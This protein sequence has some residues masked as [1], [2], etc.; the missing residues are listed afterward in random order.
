MAPDNTRAL[1]ALGASRFNLN[2]LD[3]AERLWLKVTVLE[4]DGTEACYDLGFLALNQE[5]PDY[6]GVERYWRKVIALDP[7]SQLATTVQGH[8]DDLA[9]ASLLP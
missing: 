5:V 7:G 1:L 6:A 2:D 4:P 9:A 8:L 3:E